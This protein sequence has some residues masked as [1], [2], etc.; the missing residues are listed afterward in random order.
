VTS[1]NKD[2]GWSSRSGVRIP[3]GT[4]SMLFLKTVQKFW[5]PLNLVFTGHRGSSSGYK[6]EGACSWQLTST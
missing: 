1:R 4:R 2:L 5:G 3:A 6:A